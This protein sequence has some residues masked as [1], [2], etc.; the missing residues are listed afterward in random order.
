M[1]TFSRE[2]KSKHNIIP[3]LKN[4]FQAN[5]EKKKKTDRMQDLIDI[6]FGYDETD[7]FID[8]AEAVSAPHFLNNEVIFHLWFIFL[9]MSL[10]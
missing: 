4:I 5:T 10:I 3:Y 1:R 2:S 8:N 6:G 9:R 7:S